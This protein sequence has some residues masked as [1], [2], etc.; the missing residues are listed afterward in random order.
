MKPLHGH[1]EIA[2]LKRFG[3]DRVFDF[4]EMWR[5]VVENDAIQLT[6]KQLAVIFVDK[7]ATSKVLAQDAASWWCL[8]DNSEQKSYEYVINSTQ[9]HLGREQMEKNSSGRRAALQA[10]RLPTPHP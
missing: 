6:A 2:G 7:M 8:E 5:Q 3:D 4:L 1:K 9:R 10:G